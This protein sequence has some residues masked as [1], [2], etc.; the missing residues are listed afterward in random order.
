MLCQFEDRLRTLK[1]KLIDYYLIW[2]NGSGKQSIETF[3]AKVI[4]A[5]QTAAYVGSSN[6]TWASLS[7]S[8]EMGAYIHGAAAWPISSVNDGII[9][10]CNACS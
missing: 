9:A 6:M 10:S 1:I 4:M 3:H 2:D 8:I 7:R 5:D